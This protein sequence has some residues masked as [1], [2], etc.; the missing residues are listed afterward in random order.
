MPAIDTI[1]ALTA[2]EGRGPTSDAE[3]RAAL[4]LRKE[5]GGSGR[6]ARIEPFWCRPNWALAHAWHAA[7]GLA[8]GLVAVY[9]PTIG[10]AIVL[11]ALLFVLGDAVTGVSP[12]RRLT[13]ERASQNVVARRDEPVH[14]ERLA[15][16]LTANY[17][18]GRMG[19]VY[20]GGLRR[21]VA[22]LAR[23]GPGWLAWLSAALLWM[24]A[25]A[26][27]RMMGSRGTTTGILQLPPT[28]ALVLAVALLL[29]LGSAPIGPGASDNAS[30]VAVVLALARALDV[31]PPASLRVEAVLTGTGDAGGIGL[32]RYLRAHR[33]ELAPENAIV[34]GFSA[35]GAGSPRWWERDGALIPLAYHP[36]L[37]EL[38]A[39]IA[40]AEPHLGAAPYRGRGGAPALPARMAGLPAIT[41][42]CRDE[43]GLAPR[44][45]EPGDTANG[46]DR[47]AV[48]AAIELALMLVDAIDAEVATARAQSSG[49]PSS[50]TPA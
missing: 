3:R 47:A 7:L 38:C 40:A 23:G 12:G 16:I 1:T 13:P 11:A 26:A 44:S 20:R 6:S 32:R 33:G 28:I 48:D 30:G 17:D 39:G 14:D 22:R 9:H 18:S 46:V 15:L 31:A 21:A 10:G 41:L 43:R 34:L 2:F 37:R 45:H 27:A 49:A 19:L 8:G 5:L 36:R 24:L 42:G 29:E 4:W 50:L 35:C 25:I